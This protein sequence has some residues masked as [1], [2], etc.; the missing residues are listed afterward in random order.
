MYNDDKSCFTTTSLDTKTPVKHSRFSRQV[1]ICE[2][3]DFAHRTRSSL[4]HTQ[5]QIECMMLSSD[6][7]ISCF[8]SSLAF[9][10]SSSTCSLSSNITESAYAKKPLSLYEC[11]HVSG[12][13]T[14]TFFS[15]YLA[16][17]LPASHLQ[18]NSVFNLN[19]LVHFYI[20]L[21]SYSV[22]INVLQ[23]DD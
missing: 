20:H 16:T 11:G 7:I 5:K 15:V 13:G 21:N 10:Y 17:I 4:V 12:K 8:L 14:S 1:R 23:D 3:Q 18:S 19:K 6:Y 22:A 9:N 2:S